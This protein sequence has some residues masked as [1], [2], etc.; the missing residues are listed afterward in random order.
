MLKVIRQ[1]SAKTSLFF[2]RNAEIALYMTSGSKLYKALK[3]VL[4]TVS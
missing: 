4:S 3:H 1:V 2:G